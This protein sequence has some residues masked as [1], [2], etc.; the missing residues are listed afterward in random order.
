MDFNTWKQFYGWGFC[1]KEQ[2]EQAVKQGE[3]TIDQYNSI[4]GVQAPVTMENKQVS[5][6]VPE[7]TTDESKKNE[8]EN[9][10][11]TIQ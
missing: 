5:N 3:L 2:L 6:I 4:V 10:A 9:Q 7:T 8:V 11:P 1:T